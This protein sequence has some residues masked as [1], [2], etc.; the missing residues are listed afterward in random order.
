MKKGEK[1]AQSHRVILAPKWA[2]SI[3]RL[4]LT[5]HV[6]TVAT[7]SPQQ[8]SIADNRAAQRLPGLYDRARLAR[9]PFHRNICRFQ[10]AQ[11]QN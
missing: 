5:A 8:A 9:R 11:A 7:D 10:S 4:V 2:L 6:G 3:R 1:Y